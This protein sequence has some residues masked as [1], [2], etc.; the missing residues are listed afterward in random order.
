MEKISYDYYPIIQKS[1]FKITITMRL[2]IFCNRLYL[3]DY[4]SIIQI[5][6][7]QYTEITSL[8]YLVPPSLNRGLDPPLKMSLMDFTPFITI[9]MLF[10]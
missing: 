4:D 8:R 3:H 10:V 9:S 6:F 5:R 2:N 1:N 7:E